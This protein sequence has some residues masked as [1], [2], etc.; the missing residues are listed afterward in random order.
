MLE[1]LKNFLLTLKKASGSNEEVNEKIKQEL[2]E[3]T[4][5]LLYRHNVVLR[6]FLCQELQKTLH[7]NK[8]KNRLPESVV[9]SINFAVRVLT[10]ERE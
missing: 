1:R 7:F 8:V 5:G 3:I 6:K 2:A 4:A 9:T 10:T